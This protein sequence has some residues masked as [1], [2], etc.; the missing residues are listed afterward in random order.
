MRFIYSPKYEV[1][2][3]SHV[4]PTC[5]Y[6]LVRERL[7]EEG[8]AR[9]EDFVEPA[10]ATRA[11]LELAH[12]PEYLE[13]LEHLRW[14]DRTRFSELPLTKPIVDAYVLAAGG[15]ILGARIALTAPER[16]CVHVGG[17]FHHAFADKAEGFCYINDIA[18]T[19]RV[20]QHEQCIRTAMV[21]DCD[22][23]QG[24]GTARIFNND[25][26]VFTFSIHQEN[27]YP[28]K[29]RSD[30]DIGLEDFAGDSEYL[31]AL[32]E[33]LEIAFSQHKPELLVY[34]AG[35]DPYYDDQ[36][37]AL[38]LTKEG[39]KARDELV[40]GEARKRGI[41]AVIVFAGGYARRLSDVVELHTQT[42][43]V[44]YELA[45]QG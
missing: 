22:L 8:L 39:M 30:L 29:E 10:P 41:P 13:D 19:I 1:D 9:E 4:F 18:V 43:R 11:Q 38:K 23:H 42:C 44:A 17:G 21:V 15:T 28:L 24:N 26:T 40:L 14:T 7:L 32:S 37:G 5:K 45:T 12:T 33:G 27:N 6:R 20:M 35:V 16:L 3:G 36:L 34:V 31:S 2:I 25:P